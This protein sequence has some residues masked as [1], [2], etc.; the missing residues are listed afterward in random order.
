MKNSNE[1]AEEKL[2]A[3]GEHLRKVWKEEHPVTE[4]QLAKIREVVSAQWEQ[5]QAEQAKETKDKDKDKSKDKGLG[6][7][8]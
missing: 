8:Y 4:E 3:L 1:K 7:S 6:H 2:R 5:E